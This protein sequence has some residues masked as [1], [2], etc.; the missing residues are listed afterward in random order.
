M[1]LIDDVATPEEM[2]SG[3]DPARGATA[4]SAAMAGT[5]DTPAPIG[6]PEDDEGYVEDDDEDE[7][8]E[9]DEEDD[10]EP[11]QLRRS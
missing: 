3:H 9:D 5:G 1:A 6:E 11:L 8:E 2:P 4:R 7:D 10:E